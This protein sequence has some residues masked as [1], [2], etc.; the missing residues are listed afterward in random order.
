MLYTHS[1]DSTLRLVAA[2]C[3]HTQ[4]MDGGTERVMKLGV[5]AWVERV[6]KSMSI[7]FFITHTSKG[8]VTVFNFDAPP[9]LIV[10]YFFYSA[11]HTYG[12][13]EPLE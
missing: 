5:Y 3:T 2:S 4:K 13:I 7:I 11:P 9:N 10:F 12:T 6:V 1:H 8:N